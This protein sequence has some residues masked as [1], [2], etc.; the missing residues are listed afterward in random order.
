MLI[1]QEEA[2]EDQNISFFS[3]SWQA[4]NQSTKKHNFAILYWSMND[5]IRTRVLTWGLQIH[6]DESLESQV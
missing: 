5:H 6:F 1:V 2:G 3:N 4:G